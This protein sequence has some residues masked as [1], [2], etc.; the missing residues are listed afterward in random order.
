M[1]NKGRESIYL[2]SLWYTDSQHIMDWGL[3]FTTAHVVVALMKER[4]AS[5]YLFF[6][7]KYTNAMNPQSFT[8]ILKQNTEYEQ[9]SRL[10]RSNSVHPN[11]L[12]PT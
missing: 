12:S 8:L 9:F 3:R 4:T 7:Y 5:I 6:V 1:K 11:S 2:P 10:Y